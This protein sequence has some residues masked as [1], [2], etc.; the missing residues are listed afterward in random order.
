MLSQGEIVFQEQLAR[1]V[2][3]FLGIVALAGWPPA[4]AAT[5]SF[6]GDYVLAEEGEAASGAYASITSLRFTNAGAIAGKTLLR[7]ASGTRTVDVQGAYV[8]DGANTGTMTLISGTTDEEGNAVGDSMHYRFVIAGAQIQAIRTDLSN[9]SLAELIPA[10]NLTGAFVFSQRATRDASAR[11][12]SLQVDLLGNVTGIEIQRAMGSISSA[13]VNGNFR[14]DTNGFGELTL[15]TP[16]TDEDGN[17]LSITESYA[18]VGTSDGAVA[19]RIDGASIQL[20][21]LAR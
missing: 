6:N 2:F 3:A 17:V 11:V 5:N 1:S 14:V 12:V 20:I 16:A 13:N 4:Q 21:Y 7:T 9:L 10:A 15:R 18:A 19:L 8:F